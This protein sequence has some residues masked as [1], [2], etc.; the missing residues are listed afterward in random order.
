MSPR[1]NFERVELRLAGFHLQ[2]RELARPSR[3]DARPSGTM[4]KTQTSLTGKGTNCRTFRQRTF[5]NMK[6]KLHEWRPFTVYS[7]LQ[8]DRRSSA[9]RMLQITAGSWNPLWRRPRFQPFGSVS[10]SSYSAG[11][12]LTSGVLAAPH[13]GFCLKERTN[14]IMKTNK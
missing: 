2:L 1:A 10:P 11:S 7:C 5:N 4:G 9:G 13:R 8:R 12:H 3:V 6:K 14:L